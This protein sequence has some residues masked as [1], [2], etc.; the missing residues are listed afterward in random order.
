[1]LRV[2]RRFAAGTTAIGADG[3]PVYVVK[4]GAA[5]RNIRAHDVGN[6]LFVIRDGVHDVQ[7]ANVDVTGGYRVIEN[8]AWGWYRTE[9]YPTYD[10]RQAL[11]DQK[12]LM[13]AR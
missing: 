12:T 7:I 1:M 3:E 9:L 5:Y 2:P 6:G 4:S 11:E 8:S 13:N 10:Y